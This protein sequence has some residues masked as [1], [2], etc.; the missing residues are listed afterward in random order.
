MRAL[1]PEEVQIL[2]NQAQNSYYYPIIYTAVSTGLRESELAALK[3][4]AVDPDIMLSI[5]VSQTLYKRRGICEFKEPKTT[6]S[7]RR[8]SMTPKLACFLRYYRAEREKVYHELEKELTPDDLVFTSVNMEPLNP[9][10]LTHNFVKIA[11]KAGLEGVRFHDLRHTFASLMLLRGGKPKVI[12]E[13]L[14]HS[15]VA[16]TM[17]VYSHIIE[18][19]QQDAIALLDEVLPEAAVKNSVAHL[20]PTI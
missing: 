14:G 3:W 4:R 12:S 18:G 6:H 2:L 11:K 15:S 9:S 20:S 1:T 5:S 10:V 13:A 7:R 19:M 17:D 8:V 16:F